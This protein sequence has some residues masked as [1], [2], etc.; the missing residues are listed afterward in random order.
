MLLSTVVVPCNIPWGAGSLTLIFQPKLIWVAHCRH[1]IRAWEGFFIHLF[2]LCIGIWEPIYAHKHH[3]NTY[4]PPCTH[5]I[6]DSVRCVLVR[7]PLQYTGLAS[8]TAWLQGCKVVSKC[9]TAVFTGGGRAWTLLI[10]AQWANCTDRWTHKYVDSTQLVSHKH[11]QT[12]LHTKINTV[13]AVKKL[14]F[15]GR[16]TPTATG[17]LRLRLLA[18]RGY[19]YGRATGVLWAFLHTTIHTYIQYRYTLSQFGNNMHTSVS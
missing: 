10:H 13:H 11:S 18:Y 7:C 15:Y 14:T 6:V 2:M 12:T 9:S 17:V 8:F 16:T 3:T 1:G 5:L 19:N 4:L